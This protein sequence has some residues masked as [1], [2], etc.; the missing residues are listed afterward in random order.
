MN[1]EV[2]WEESEPEDPQTGAIFL[3]LK[4]YRVFIELLSKQSVQ[5]NELIYWNTLDSVELF[6]SWLANHAEAI[7]ALLPNSNIRLY[8]LLAASDTE[9]KS[10]FKLM[11][12]ISEA[13]KLKGLRLAKIVLDGVPE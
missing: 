7:E 13:A 9:G 10:Y 4:I 11:G 12:S 5:H 3:C 8:P 1:R 2:S 6:F